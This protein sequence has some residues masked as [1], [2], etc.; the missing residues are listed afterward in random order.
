MSWFRS[1]RRRRKE[2]APT[3]GEPA[4]NGRPAGLPRAELVGRP[5]ADLHELAREHGVPRYRLLRKDDLIGALAGDGPAPVSVAKEP[6]TP[7]APA[8]AISEEQSASVELLEAVQRLAHQLS[9]TASAPGPSDLEE[10][11]SSPMTRLLVARENGE[12]VGMLT[13]VVY[14]IPTGVCAWIEDVVVDEGAR[15]RG[16]GQR[17]TREAMKIASDAGARTVDLTSRRERQAANR[18]YRKLGFEQRDTNIYRFE[19]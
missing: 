9:S 11:V 10:I 16:A 15:Q 14:R 6:P 1:S 3:A 19:P 13:L 17:L 8:V 4:G 12:I 7:A 5:L 18:M 2:E